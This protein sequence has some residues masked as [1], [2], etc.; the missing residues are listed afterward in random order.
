MLIVNAPLGQGERGERAGRDSG[1]V[2][3]ARQPAGACHVPQLSYQPVEKGAAMRIASK[4][5]RKAEEQLTDS[6]L[7]GI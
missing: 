6:A 5:L 7:L 4:K 3:S 2:G 1:R